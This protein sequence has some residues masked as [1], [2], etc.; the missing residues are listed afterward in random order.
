MTGWDLEVVKAESF[1]CRGVET[2]GAPLTQ[3][4]FCV[5]YKVPD[6]INSSLKSNWIQFKCESVVVSG[7]GK[8]QEKSRTVSVSTAEC[9][10][11]VQA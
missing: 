5:N 1:M 2:A 4:N 7:E 3:S 9:N 6:K 11:A 10:G 8:E